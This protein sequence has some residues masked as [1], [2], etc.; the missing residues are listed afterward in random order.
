MS[1]FQMVSQ[2]KIIVKFVGWVFPLVDEELGRWR[3]KAAASPDEVL[4]AQALASIRDKRFHAQGGSVYALYPGVEMKGFVALVVALQ[5]ISDYLDNLCDRVG[6]EDE[7]AFRRL[8]L[9]M[10]E[11]LSP[12]VDPSDYYTYYPHHEDGGYLQELVRECQSQVAKLP[13]YFLVQ[14]DVLFLAG[15]YSD[16]QTYKHLPLAI[17]E[18]K[19][20]EWLEPYMVGNPDFSKWEFAAATGST[21]GMFMLCAAAANPRLTREEAARIKEAYFPWVSGLH[22]LLDYFIDQQEDEGT[23]DLNFI[24]YYPNRQ[25]CGERLGWFLEQSLIKVKKLSQPLFHLTVIEG[26]LAMYLSDPKTGQEPVRTV[27][28]QLL[29]TAGRRT[30][31]FHGLC[32]FLR[33]KKVI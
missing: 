24:T 9:A 26:L 8:H 4:A 19:M 5:T 13:G 12:G 25:Q 17:R 28:A 10:T 14:E 21:L 3:L 29:R 1:P 16:L 32:K 27:S 31:L 15:L 6:L 30:G 20:I 11:A 2:L 7:K 33:K 18:E 22:I 23:G